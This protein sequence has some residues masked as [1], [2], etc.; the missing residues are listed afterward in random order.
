MTNNHQFIQ[1]T[2][3]STLVWSTH[4]I[5]SEK[6]QQ[7]SR[8]QRDIYSLWESFCEFS[9]L[10]LKFFFVCFQLS[11]S[12]QKTYTNM[13][14]WFSVKT[15]SSLWFTKCVYNNNFGVAVSFVLFLIIW[16]NFLG[17]TFLLPKLLSM[18]NIQQLNMELTIEINANKLKS[19]S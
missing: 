7:W 11:I 15:K 9:L 13:D 16:N 3:A 8:T 19:S 10:L 5:L 6:E 17:R 2:I 18:T 4:A 1:S 12:Y 14:L